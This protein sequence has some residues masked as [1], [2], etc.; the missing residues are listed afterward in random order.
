[1]SATIDKRLQELG[2]VLPRPAAPAGAY[3]PAVV[4]GELCFIAGQLPF[5]SGEIRYRGHLGEDVGIEDGYA[6]AR[7]CG[8]N[9]LAQLREACGDDLGRVR[10]VVRLCGFVA[11][12][13]SFVDHPKVI[14]GASDLML[15]VFGEA[16][17]HA[18]VAVGAASLPLAA[19]VEVEGLF[20]IA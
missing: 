5:E 15:A 6:A 16:G 18:R 19:A 20:R 3:V 4:V 1:M 13:P 2:L 9:L 14:N 7:L 17:R 8:L 12:T 10:G 11:C